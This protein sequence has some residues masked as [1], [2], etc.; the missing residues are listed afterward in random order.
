MLEPGQVE[1]LKQLMALLPCLVLKYKPVEEMKKERNAAMEARAADELTSKNNGEAF[2][3]L[4]RTDSDG[5]SD[6]TL[7]I[8]NERVGRR[9]FAK[10]VDCESFH[11][12]TLPSSE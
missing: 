7:P 11:S 5:F 10:D 6:I 12:V 9:E 2:P 8:N 4:R 1:E 3:S